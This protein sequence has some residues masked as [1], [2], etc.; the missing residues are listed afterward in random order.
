MDT[1]LQEGGEVSKPT[2]LNHVFSSSE[3][4][5]GELMNV[6][7]LPNSLKH[8]TLSLVHCQLATC[9]QY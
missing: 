6:V 2:F 3:E 1:L 8:L 9:Q 7:Q 4:S 5:M